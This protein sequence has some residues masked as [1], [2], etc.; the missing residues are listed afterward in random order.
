MKRILAAVLL[1]CFIST[2]VFAAPFYA[3][4]QLDDTSAGILFGAQLNKTYA[5]ETHFSR[6]NSSITHAGVTV[7]TS[8][9][10]IGVVG[11]ALFP[12]KL[13]D[14]LPYSLFVKGGFERTSNSET[15]SIPS[16]ATLT[17]PY[18]GKIDSSK[19]QVIFGGGAEYDF[20]RSLTGRMGMDFL[21]KKRSINMVAIFRF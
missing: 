15:Y 5:I 4:V 10:A 6:S 8:S 1:L 12:M 3:G 18:S 13:N 7:E 20:T 17:L 19:N 14:V 16:S 2:P 11:L 9:N 21:G